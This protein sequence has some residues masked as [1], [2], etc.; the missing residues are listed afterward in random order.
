MYVEQICQQRVFRI[1]LHLH[2][3]GTSKGVF[4]FFFLIVHNHKKRKY[5]VI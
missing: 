5:F 2:L 1:E 3:D 4:L